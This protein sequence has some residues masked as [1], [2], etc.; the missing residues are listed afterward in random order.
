MNVTEALEWIMEHVRKI[1]F[2]FI[3]VDVLRG[4]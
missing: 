4:G 3:S 1:L 2:F